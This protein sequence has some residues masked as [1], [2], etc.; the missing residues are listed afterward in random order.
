MAVFNFVVTDAAERLDEHHDGGNAGA[1][2]LGGIMQRTGRQAVRRVRDLANRLVA[3]FDQMR[4]KRDRL[5]I[6]D[7]RP[8]DGA[9]LFGSKAVAGFARLARTCAPARRRPNRADRGW[10][11]S[12][13]RRP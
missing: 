11:R 12:G 8:F 2:D 1:R 5:D 7:A 4:M 6:P 13:R 10:L 3:E 9:A